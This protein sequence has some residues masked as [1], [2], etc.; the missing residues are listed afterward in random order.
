MRHY[1]SWMGKN[2]NIGLRK[3]HISWFLSSIDYITYWI[4]MTMCARQ[5]D[6][7]QIHLYYIPE[8]DVIGVVI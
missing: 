1:I 7:Y 8:Y 3:F 2:G 5:V 6:C 4:P